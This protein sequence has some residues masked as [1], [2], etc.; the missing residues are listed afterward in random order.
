MRE[1]Y[2]WYPH[3][4]TEL[5]LQYTK[6]PIVPTESTW[7]VLMLLVEMERGNQE[8]RENVQ[9]S[10][11]P[12]R[13]TAIEE[14]PNQHLQHPSDSDH[15]CH[16]RKSEHGEVSE[17]VGST[18]ERSVHAFSPRWVQEFWSEFF[19][20]FMILVFGSGSI[21]QVSTSSAR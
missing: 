17:D 12:S 5:T 18:P 1:L 20:T 8:S 9:T 15:Q 2:F 14:H 10:S 21:A 7:Q 4:Y 19:G 13:F 3:R 16:N 11:S 6:L